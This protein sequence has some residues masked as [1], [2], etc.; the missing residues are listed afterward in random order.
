MFVLF[1]HSLILV[2][3]P[4][5]ERGALWVSKEMEPHRQHCIRF[6]LEP[7]ARRFWDVDHQNPPSILLR[8]LQ[9]IL[10][11][12]GKRTFR[13]KDVFALLDACDGHFFPTENRDKDAF[14]E[15][16]DAATQDLG[17]DTIETV[18]DPRWTH[19]DAITP[20]QDEWVVRIGTKPYTV[21]ISKMVD[22]EQVYHSVMDM[23]GTHFYA[24][25]MQWHDYFGGT[26]HVTSKKGRLS[27]VTV[28]SLLGHRAHASREEA[29]AL[30]AYG[31]QPCP[32]HSQW[33]EN[34]TLQSI[35][36]NFEN[37]RWIVQYIENA[38]TNSTSRK[39]GGRMGAGDKAQPFK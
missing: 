20:V 31:L 15:I 13:V 4:A 17:V 2:R 26:H 7:I 37:S 25:H 24:Y 19:V 34:R 22:Y 5:N 1:S 12:L 16:A 28:M 38:P 21:T 8:G 14:R 23:L 29:R 39:N 30:R 18:L 10:N 32:R 27:L 33:R 3:C 11:R 6:W 9:A 36:V 35:T